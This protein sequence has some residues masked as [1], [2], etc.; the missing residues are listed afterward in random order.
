[1]FLSCGLLGEQVCD[2]IPAQE[3][4]QA[5]MFY[6]AFLDFIIRKFNVINRVD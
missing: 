6:F 4:R 3:G 1:M 5:E 2:V